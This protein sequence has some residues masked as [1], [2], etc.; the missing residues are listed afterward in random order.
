MSAVDGGPIV[1]LI[2]ASAAQYLH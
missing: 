1:A 2:A